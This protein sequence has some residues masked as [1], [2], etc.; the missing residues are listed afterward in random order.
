MNPT[1]S[2]LL[3]F[4]QRTGCTIYK[5]SGEETWNICDEEYKNCT[6]RFALISAMNKQREA[7]DAKLLDDM[8]QEKRD[9]KLD[10]NN[11]HS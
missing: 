3:N 6:L 7:L 11:D 8:A 10:S 4:I 9:Q 5:I 1:D 2:E